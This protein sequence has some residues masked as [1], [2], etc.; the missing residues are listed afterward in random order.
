MV[1]KALDY[2]RAKLERDFAALR[3]DVQRLTADLSELASILGGDLQVEA[4]H[5]ARQLSHSALRA[6]RYARHE[7]EE[8]GELVRENPGKA[9]GVVGAVLLAGI[10]IWCATSLGSRRRW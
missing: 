5:R 2:E 9:A 4:T 7:A 1:D 8:L 3:E 6:A 10:A